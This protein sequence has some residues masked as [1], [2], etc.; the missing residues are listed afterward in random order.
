MENLKVLLVSFSSQARLFL[1][2]INFLQLILLQTSIDAAQNI[3]RHNKLYMCGIKDDSLF[4]SVHF[5][6]RSPLFLS[7]L[8][9]SLLTIN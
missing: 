8:P 3:N 1:T 2:A 4:F 7:L 9:P 6:P 5:P